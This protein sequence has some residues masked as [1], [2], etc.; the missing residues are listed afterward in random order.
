MDS[1]RLGA[2]NAIEECQFQFQNRRW[3]CSTVGD[4]VESDMD[5]IRKS[6][7]DLTAGGNGGKGGGG[8]GRNLGPSSFGGM[9]GDFMNHHPQQPM[10][11]PYKSSMAFGGGGGDGPAASNVL[12]RSGNS[13]NTFAAS[14]NGGGGNNYNA[15]YNSF[16][17]SNGGG[18]GRRQSQRALRRGRRLSRR[19]TSVRL[20][21]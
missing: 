14:N 5:A 16:G 10:N 7:G 18:G 2:L 4:K 9:H 11:V 12:R 13:I 21:G 15:M 20:F 8:R 1:V 17:G 3:N 19:G 6:L